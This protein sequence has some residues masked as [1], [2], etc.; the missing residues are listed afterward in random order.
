MQKIIE[1]RNEMDV[2]EDTDEVES[3]ILNW[4]LK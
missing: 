2:S 4:I 3:T 1:R